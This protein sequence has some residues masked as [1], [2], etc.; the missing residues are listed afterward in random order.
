MPPPTEADQGLLR[1]GELGELLVGL[2]V[3]TVLVQPG[4]YRGPL[5]L[6]SGVIVNVI[7][8]AGHNPRPSYIAGA[9]ANAALDAFTYHGG[10]ALQM[11]AGG[12]THVLA[13][14]ASEAAVAVTAANARH[15]GLAN[16]TVAL[17][18]AGR[19]PE[20]GSWDL[21]LANPPYYGNYRIAELFLTAARRALRPHGRCRR[22]PKSRLKTPVPKARASAARSSCWLTRSPGISGRLRPGRWPSI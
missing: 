12:A 20:P 15:N 8:G 10:F 11:A 7:G 3:D 1:R 2:G 13:L 19:V 17:E 4:T 16:V 5:T 21:A 6:K 14:D 22:P 9:P 18:S